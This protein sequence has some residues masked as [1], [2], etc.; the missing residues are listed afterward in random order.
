MGV[1]YRCEY[2]WHGEFLTEVERDRCPDHT[3]HRHPFKV[4][5]NPFLRKIGLVLVSRFS[6]DGMKYYGLELRR[7]KPNA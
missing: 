3:V 1:R 7:Y 5:L 6:E 4:F 2:K